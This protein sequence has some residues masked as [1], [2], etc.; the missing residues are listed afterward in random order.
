[1]DF[2]KKGEKCENIFMLLTALLAQSRFI[3]L[4]QYVLLNKSSTKVFHKE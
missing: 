4:A 1:M 2:S 3:Q